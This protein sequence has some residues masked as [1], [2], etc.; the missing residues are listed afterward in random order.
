MLNIFQVFKLHKHQQCIHL[1]SA[2]AAD[3]NICTYNA[4][5]CKMLNYG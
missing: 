3:N 5:I 1:M 4:V 2:F